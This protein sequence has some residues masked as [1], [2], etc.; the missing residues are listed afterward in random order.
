MC[1]NGSV[2]TCG[3]Q[4]LDWVRAQ[5]ELLCVGPDAQMYI[6]THE[7]APAPTLESGWRASWHAG[8]R[9]KPVSCDISYDTRP[10]SPPL[11]YNLQK[12]IDTRT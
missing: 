3:V 8:W 6:G 12:I 2:C 11:S 10:L 1:T 5:F 9:G 7:R 4:V